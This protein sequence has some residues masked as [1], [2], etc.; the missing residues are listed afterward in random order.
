MKKLIIS[1]LILLISAPCFAGGDPH[2]SAARKG[3]D[4]STDV[5]ALALPT[6]ALV[7]TLCMKDWKGL[8]QGVETAAVTAGVTYLLKYTV[9]EPRPDGSN[10]HSF[11]SGH[12]AVSF[13]TATYLQR[14]Y[15]WKFGVPAYILS[16]YV[17]WGRCFAQQHYW[18]DVVIGGAIGAG[19]ALI[20]TRP[21]AKKHNL[22]VS[23]VSN[24]SSIGLYASFEF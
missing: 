6:A 4:T 10:L 19:S 16:C 7:G 20:F 3:V 17:G 21:W 18:Y 13:A 11:P 5:V 22:Q 9:K 2:R 8:L 12:S 24:G 1:T 14:R 23:P 15:G